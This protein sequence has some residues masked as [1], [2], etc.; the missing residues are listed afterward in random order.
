MCSCERWFRRFE[1]GD[2][3]TR[4]EERRGTWKTAKKFEDVKLQALLDEDD[5]QTQKQLA[6]QLDVGQ[7]VVS[8]RPLEM[9]KIQKIDR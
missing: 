2:F 4:Q 1:S 6:N 5:F 3:E 9:G 8:N 7:Q